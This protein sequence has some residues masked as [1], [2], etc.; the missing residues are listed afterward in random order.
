VTDRY[1]SL[2]AR[3]AKAN[4]AAFIPFVV[5]GDP[6]IDRSLAIIRALVDAGAD[7]LELGFPFSD[8]VADG[9][10]VQAA[11]ARALAGAA[12]TAQC[13]RVVAAIRA[14][15]AQLPIG[16]LVYANLVVRPGPGAFYRAAARA[17][18]DSVLVAD[19]PLEEAG[20]FERAALANGVQ[21]V[22]IAPPN[23]S[24]ARL[25]AIAERGRGYTYLV[26]RR[27]VT[28]DE[29]REAE[30]LADRVARL[31]SLGAPPAMV[32]FGIAQP[33]QVRSAIGSGAAGVIVGSALIRQFASLDPTALAGAATL[34][35]ALKA[36]TRPVSPRAR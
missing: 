9:P 31:R 8:P 25:A 17:G 36:A 30:G 11:Q 15:W 21:P 27:G 1:Q 5:S 6:S 28:G 2:F 24:E 26:S 35:G 18:V 32:G 14:Q 13:W 22:L 7:G 34:A 12:T 10:V 33:A 19:A 20:P 16:L 4:E 3:L 23:A 29:R